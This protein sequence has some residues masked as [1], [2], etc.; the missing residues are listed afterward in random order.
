MTWYG[1]LIRNIYIVNRILYRSII[2]LASIDTFF[3]SIIAK[4]VISSVW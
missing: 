4:Q 1:N 3:L 2:F